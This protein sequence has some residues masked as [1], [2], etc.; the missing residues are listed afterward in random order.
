[1]VNIAY[2]IKG[3]KGS[4][5]RR[6]IQDENKPWIDLYSKNFGQTT[7]IVTRGANWLKYLGDKTRNT[8]WRDTFNSYIDIIK[9]NRPR[10]NVDILASPLWYNPDI[11]IYI[12]KL[13]LRS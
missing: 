2:F 7:N 3:L 6:L 12:F 1:M 8:F 4:W 5:V 13:F 11:S 10:N 9:E